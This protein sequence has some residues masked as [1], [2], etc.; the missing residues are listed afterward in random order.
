MSESIE[1]RL[2]HDNTLDE[3]V[4]NGARFHLEQMDNNRWWLVVENDGHS[5]NVWLSARGK[6]TAYFEEATA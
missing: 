5:V 6:I 1:V 2:N 3:I 4:A